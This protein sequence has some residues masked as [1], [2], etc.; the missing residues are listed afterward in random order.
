MYIL[1][2]LK[3]L[4]LNQNQPLTT[5]YGSSRPQSIVPAHSYSGGCIRLVA[6]ITHMGGH[7]HKLSPT[8]AGHIDNTI[9]Y[10]NG[11]HSIVVL[12][13]LGENVISRGSCCL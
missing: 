3:K 5:D 8:V 2:A 6:L 12:L 9:W 11:G 4:Q 13:T 10:G 1:A 7:R